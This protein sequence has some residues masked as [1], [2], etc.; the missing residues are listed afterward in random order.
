MPNY[1]KGIKALSE[2]LRKNAKNLADSKANPKSFYSKLPVEHQQAYIDDVLRG[3]ERNNPEKAFDE[4]EFLTQLRNRM[5]TE[6]QASKAQKVFEASQPIKEPDLHTR[7]F[8]L[9]QQA[10]DFLKQHDPAFFEE[11]NNAMKNYD[12]NIE[13]V[14]DYS[15][16]PG[17]QQQELEQIVE[18]SPLNYHLSKDPIEGSTKLNFPETTFNRKYHNVPVPSGEFNYIG[19]HKPADYYHNALWNYIN[20]GSD[21]DAMLE[22][23]FQDVLYKPTPTNPQEKFNTI[24]QYKNALDKRR[25]ELDMK[26]KPYNRHK[27]NNM[28]AIEDYFESQRPYSFENFESSTLSEGPRSIQNYL[29]VLHNR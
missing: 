18:Q 26:N 20:R 27:L 14:S 6:Q 21:R 5:A 17:I 28:R 29:D 8:E 1:A 22:E 10:D 2:V 24:N 25:Y 16:I 9:E 7:N 23:F 15:L 19:K 4:A 11:L 3:M 12:E 13:S